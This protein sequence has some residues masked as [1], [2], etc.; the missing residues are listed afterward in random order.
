MWQDS[1]QVHGSQRYRLSWRH[2]GQ[3]LQ[4]RQPGVPRFSVIK[5]EIS[6]S[7]ELVQE[8][9]TLVTDLG[10]MENQPPPAEPVV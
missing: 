7:C 4:M 3:T 1:P 2:S 9:Q 6:E 5:R 10:V 8:T